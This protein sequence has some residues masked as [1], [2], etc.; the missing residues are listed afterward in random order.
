MDKHAQHNAH[1]EPGFI[2]SVGQCCYFSMLENGH[3][4]YASHII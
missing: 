4:H 1:P 2:G 3:E